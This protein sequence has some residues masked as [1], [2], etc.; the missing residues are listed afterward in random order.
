MREL[1]CLRCA[2]QMEFVTREKLQLGEYGAF[3][4]HLPSYD[5]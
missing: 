4:G 2:V 3:L 5:T 1:M